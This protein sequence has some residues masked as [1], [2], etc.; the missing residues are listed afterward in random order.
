PHMA[1]VLSSIVVFASLVPLIFLWSRLKQEP[2]EAFLWAMSATII[3]ALVLSAHTHIYDD[4]LLLV[5]AALTLP[6]LF[7]AEENSVCACLWRI[8]FLSFPWLSWGLLF[9]CNHFDSIKRTPFALLNIV[10]SICALNCLLKLG[11]AK[12]QQEQS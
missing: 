9:S 4:T 6:L 3:L 5:P 7:D 10:L 11:R 2:K 8:I 12:V 1:L